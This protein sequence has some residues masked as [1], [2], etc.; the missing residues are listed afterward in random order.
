MLYTE[1]EYLEVCRELFDFL[2]KYTRRYKQDHPETSY[3]EIL[4]R[5]SIMSF[6]IRNGSSELRDFPEEV[7]EFLKE[8]EKNMQRSFRNLPQKMQRLLSLKIRSSYRECP[9]AGTL[10]E[11]MFRRTGVC[12]TC[13][14]L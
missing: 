7:L 4:E 5:R 3:S 11:R 8:A 6:I 10:R 12:S 1:Q 14:T 13:G 9:C 2:L